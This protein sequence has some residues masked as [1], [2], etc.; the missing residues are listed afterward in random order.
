MAALCFCSTVTDYLTR[1]GM[2]PF[3]KQ[4]LSFCNIRCKTRSFPTLG[5]PSQSE[6]EA[7]PVSR[8][9][10]SFQRAPRASQ[11]LCAAGDGRAQ[12]S[13]SRR[14]WT[15]VWKGRNSATGPA[16]NSSAE[17]HGLIMPCCLPRGRSHLCGARTG[18]GVPG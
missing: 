10:F 3:Y 1:P 18:A 5:V 14:C 2:F 9:M 13:R 7:V 15:T 4:Q 17:E 6:V 12:Q 11:V 16:S 8:R